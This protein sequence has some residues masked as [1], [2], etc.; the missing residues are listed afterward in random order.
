MPRLSEEKRAVLESMTR[1]ALYEA[2]VGILQDEGLQGLTMER[3]AVSAGVAKGTVYNY[4]RDKLDVVT[5]I[6]GQLFRE[7]AAEIERSLE[8]E[9]D[10]GE[11]LGNC[12]RCGRG[13]MDK[14]RFLQVAMLEMLMETPSDKRRELLRKDPENMATGAFIKFFQRGIDNGTFRKVKPE[15]LELVLGAVMDG[16]SVRAELN[17]GSDVS[18]PELLDSVLDILLN[19]MRAADGKKK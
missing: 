11:V 10:P 18:D 1:E 13:K 2:A 14:F 19:G 6:N 12:L 17:G 5:F 4:F 9:G 16:L 7:S 3:L 15:L 8:A